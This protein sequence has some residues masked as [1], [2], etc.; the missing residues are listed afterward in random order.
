MEPVFNHPAAIDADGVLLV[1]GYYPTK[2]NRVVFQL[3]YL[4][5]GDWKLVGIDVKLKE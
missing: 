1:Q 3:K 5:E 2:P 4:N